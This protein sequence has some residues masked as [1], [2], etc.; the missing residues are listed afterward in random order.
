MIAGFQG[1]RG[2]FSEEAA[3]ALFGAVETRGYLTFDALVAAVDTLEVT[4]ALL[5]CENTIAG[6]IARA[7]DLLFA[8]DRIRIVGEVTQP[9]EQCLIALPGAKIED[10]QYVASHP[11]ALEQCRAF[12]LNVFLTIRMGGFHGVIG[13]HHQVV[14]GR[15]TP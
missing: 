10:I 15:C 3:Q 11:V 2:A 14:D 9:I 1:E 6:P 12:L 4:H 7:Y 5:P 13:C 8:Y